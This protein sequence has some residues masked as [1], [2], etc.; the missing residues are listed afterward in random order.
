MT[1]LADPAR[2]RIHLSGTC[3]AGCAVMHEEARDY[4]SRI[5]AELPKRRRIVEIGGRNVNGGIRDLF[6]DAAYISTDIAAGEGVDVVAD[7]ADYT[8]PWQPDTVVCCETLEHAQRASGIIFNAY[9]MLAPGGVFIM[10]AAA[11]PRE[12]HSG[13]DGSPWL[14]DKEHYANITP[15][16]LAAWLQR[17]LVAEVEYDDIHGDIR[18]VASKARPRTAQDLLK[19]IDWTEVTDAP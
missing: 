14:F 19:M 17:F 3:S 10:T 12:V 13:W 2:S 18:A 4:V 9:H 6:G 16:A 15:E 8:P 1:L 7:G 5:V 11:P